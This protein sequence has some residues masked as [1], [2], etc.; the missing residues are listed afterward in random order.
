M[1]KALNFIRSMRFGMILLILIGALCVLA[2][3]SGNESIY[4][5]WYFILAFAML[6]LNLT[7]CSVL[8]VFGIRAQRK[9]LYRKAEADEATLAVKQAEP[10]LKSHHFRKTDEGYL[11]HGL[12]FYGSFL[13]HASMLLL[14]ISAAC[15][16]ALAERQDINL[17]VGDTAELPDGTQLTVE[18]FSL[19]DESGKTEYTSALRA[20]LPDGTEAEGRALV[21]HPLRL[22]RYIIYQQNFAYAAVLG[23]RTDADAEEEALKL[24]EPAF[25]SLDGE[26]GIW[27]SQLFGNVTE[28]N[29]EVRVS[30]GTE[31]IN[32]AYEVSIIEGGKEQGGL[33]YPGTTV[34]AAGV[35][36]T[37]YEPEAFPGL[38]VKTQPDWALWLLYASFA[39]MTVGLYLCFFQIPEAAQIKA[40]GIAIAGRK[41]ISQQI[42]QYR[43]ELQAAGTAQ[44]GAQ[45]SERG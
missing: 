45:K 30:R 35:Y 21:N 44:K 41:D 12:G 22:G 2:T 10:W 11:K 19:E 3:V 33:I 28:E 34:T 39:M 36:Y 13:T 4:S 42:V 1:K 7:L 37:F 8:R 40:D 26:N 20:L 43:A 31:V 27:Y 25:L 17:C 5:S 14:M 6:G 16:F 9:A 23:I 18:A 32:P 38:R 29:G 15:L 24:D